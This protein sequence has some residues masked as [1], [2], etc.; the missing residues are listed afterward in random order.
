MS[1][2]TFNPTFPRIGDI[3][4]NITYAAMGRLISQWEAVEFELSRL[5]AALMWDPDG[6]TMQFYGK[7]RI[8]RE[9]LDI[10]KIAFD[11]HFMKSP[12]QHEEGIVDLLLSDITNC[13]DH[14]NEVAH[15]MVLDVAQ[16]SLFDNRMAPNPG[17]KPSF[18]LL[19]PYYLLRKHDESG[20]T[21]A[22]SSIEICELVSQMMELQL[23]SRPI[24]HA[25]FPELWPQE[26]REPSHEK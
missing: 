6:R 22:Y 3:D 20:P 15:G 19:P 16:T 12:C 2:F 8:F 26:H 13:A 25:L 24:R 4:E 9:R 14:R 7:P 23:R 11:G 1:R 17:R 21:F 10:L 5:F 18:L